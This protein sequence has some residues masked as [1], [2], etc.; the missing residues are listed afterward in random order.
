MDLMSI[1]TQ[2]IL[3][4]ILVAVLVVGPNRI[5]GISRTMGNIMRAIKKTTA[6]LT[7]SVTKE[8][9]LEEKEKQ[10]APDPANKEQSPKDGASKS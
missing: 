9:E 2:E 8:L 4:I 3:M 1:G 6:E 10:S 5:V 7:T